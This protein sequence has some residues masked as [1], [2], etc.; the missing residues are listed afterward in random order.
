[1][2]T[3]LIEQRAK[4]FSEEHSFLMIDLGSA[5]GKPEGYLG[6]D[7][8]EAEGVD[9]VCDVTKG[10]PFEDSSVGLI[11]AFDFIEHIEDK[12]FLFNEFYRVLA[13]GGTLLTHTPSS[14]GRGAFQDPTHVAYYN[15]NSFWYFTDD[16]YKS[17]VPEIQCNFEVLQLQTHF[18]S[19]FHVTHNIPYVIAHLE[20]VKND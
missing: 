10:L 14:D 16:F 5:H 3:M 7:M 19:E 15:E 13:N 1:M 2:N 12:I 8:Y 4:A 20:A 17:F 9:I 18:P 11:R 6:V